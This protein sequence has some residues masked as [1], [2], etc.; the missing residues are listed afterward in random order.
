MGNKPS[1]PRPRPRPAPPA[2]QAAQQS[3]RQIPKIKFR[4]LIIGRANAGKTTILQR[5]CDTTDS[6]NIY[7]ENSGGQREEVRHGCLV[8]LLLSSYPTHTQ[9]KLDPSTEVS[10]QEKL[11]VVAVLTLSQRGEHN[12]NDELAFS[13]HTGYIFHDSRGIE[14]GGTEELEILWRFMQH[15]ASGN[16]LQSR[17]HAIWFGLFCVLMV[18]TNDGHMFSGTASRWTTDD[19]HLS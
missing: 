18:T 15:R 17:L 9:V 12:I 5:V 3:R 8:V 19:Q 1:R 2:A 11:S 4:V 6:P 13:N 16:R 14:C 10:E 7:R